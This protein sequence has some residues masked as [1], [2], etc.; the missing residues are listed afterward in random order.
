M[1]LR[2]SRPTEQ[3]KPIVNYKNMKKYLLMVK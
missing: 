2:I 3:A 1:D